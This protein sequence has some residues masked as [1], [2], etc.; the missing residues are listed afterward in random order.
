VVVRIGSIFLVGDAA[1]RQPPTTGLGLNTAIQ[2]VHNLCWKLAT[3]LRGQAADELLDSYEAERRPVGQANADWALFSFTNH[4]LIDAGM[5]LQPG[6]TVEQNTAALTAF[7]ADTPMGASLRAR[8]GVAIGTQTME[9]QAHDI[10]IGFSYA[11]RA[12][13]PDGSQAPPRDP[14]G[15]D[16]TP[17][18]RPGHRLPHAWLGRNGER[19]LHARPG[20]A[21]QLRP[22]DRARRQRV[23]GGDVSSRGRARRPAEHVPDRRERRTHGH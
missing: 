23:D 15:R 21:R 8:G 7:F 2:D 5:G 12:L 22:V 16:Y 4:S 6:A 1:H 19:A 11:E 3:V 9:F 10:E 20:P 14:F 18:T 17:T 13:A